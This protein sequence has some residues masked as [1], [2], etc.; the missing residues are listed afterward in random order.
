MPKPF[1]TLLFLV[2]NSGTV[3]DK[4]ELM[5]AVW[6]DTVVEENNLSQN[7]SQLRRALGEK[8]GQHRYIV[9]VPGR[10]FRFVAE[11]RT[12]TELEKTQESDK[13]S[14][15]RLE[16]ATHPAKEVT[17]GS[18][19]HLH[20]ILLAC[21]VVTLAGGSLLLW[22]ALRTG[23]PVGPSLPVATKVKT[24]AVLP[25]KPLLPNEQ[26]QALELGMADTLIAKLSNSREVVVRPISAVRKYGALDQDPLAAG[27]ELQVETVLDGYIQK[28]GDSIRVTARLLSSGDGRQLWAGQFDQKMTDIFAVQDAISER[29]AAALAL[30]LTGAENARLKRRDTPNVEA[31]QLCLSGRY[32][33]SQRGRAHSLEKARD[34]FQ[35]SI[36]LDP[37][38]ALA[39]AG[40][41]DAYLFLAN[42]EYGGM[43]PTQLIPKAKDAAS[44]AV[45]LDPYLVEAHGTLGR[46]VAYERNW[47]AAESELKR[48][49]EL[50]PN[51]SD[52]RRLYA[53]FLARQGRLDE[54]LTEAR[55][56]W[57]LEPGSAN[58][59]IILGWVHY[60]RREYDKAIEQYRQALEVDP[61]Y[62]PAHFRL[63]LAYI[64]KR[65]FEEAI[66][67]L[68]TASRLSERNARHLAVLAYALSIS[69][70]R[71]EAD[72]ILN[73]LRVRSQR[74]FVSS[75]DF[76]LIY[77]GL[78]DKD[79]ALKSLEK[80][81]D[82]RDDWLLQLKVDPMMDS[83]RDEP[84]FEELVRKV[85]SQ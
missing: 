53:V 45:T 29:V 80:A 1:E 3:L 62:H 66:G 33:L 83:I 34:T 75:F 73:E 36:A 71:S 52:G 57:E 39:Y 41:A 59:M 55:L 6:P 74:S 37:N 24:I 78:G 18:R 30:T 49:L 17:A 27:R 76:A 35:Q 82:E 64:Q 63:G 19:R 40:L 61:N 15:G 67:E 70:R 11:V 69:G 8:P 7:I 42:S 4:D 23:A 48:S 2:R 54:A 46:A 58:R 65:M 10:G 9:T 43:P 14:P 25:F 44:R 81:D 84:R 21:I 47:A 32:F 85:Q 13:T 72:K 60:F 56:A 51:Y 26:D 50:D 22:R 5:R 38:Y 68:Q 20:W 16:P 77:L 31:Y 79:S 12:G 28:R